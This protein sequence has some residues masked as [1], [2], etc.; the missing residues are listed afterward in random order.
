MSGP[1]LQ[2]RRIVI[3]GAAAGIGRATAEL[4]AA[5]GAS[6]ALLDRDATSLGELAGEAISVDVSDEKSVA[7]AIT[8]AASAMGGIDGVVNVAGIFPVAA[9]EDTS[10]DLWEKTI[11]VNLTGPFLIARAALPHLRK[12]GKATIV[13]LSSASAIVPFRELSAYGASKGG[14]ITLSKVWASELGPKIRVN[15]VCP[16]MTRTRMVSDWHPDSEK[17]AQTA[18]ATYALQRIA[19]PVEVAKAILFLTSDESSFTT[20]STMTVDG[21]RTFH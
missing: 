9:L 2:G 8:K 16:G 18:K 5:E 19:E 1:R 13:N 11:A 3:T 15:V 10:L 12:A 17:L 21:G 14:I 7:T 6:L 4:F 20:G